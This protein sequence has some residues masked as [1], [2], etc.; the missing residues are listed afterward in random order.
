MISTEVSKVWK[1]EW[2]LAYV[3]AWKVTFTQ[4]NVLE[5]W[6]GAGLFS[7]NFKNVLQHIEIP[8]AEVLP[9]TIQTPLTTDNLKLDPD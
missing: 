3:N 8:P 5:G 9:Q 6:R 4:S 1:N 7:H 2:L